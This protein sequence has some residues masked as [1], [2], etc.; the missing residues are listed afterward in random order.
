MCTP[1]SSVYQFATS[2]LEAAPAA[3]TRARIAGS[4]ALTHDACMASDATTD[5]HDE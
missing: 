1:S 4:D 5:D 2:N 3:C